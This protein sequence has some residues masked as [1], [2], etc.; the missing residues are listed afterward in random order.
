M[1]DSDVAVHT[2]HCK[3]KNTGEHVVVVNRNDYFTEQLSKRPGPH[4]ILGTLE[5]QCA[6][7]Q[8]VSQSQI[9]DVNVGC[10][11][12]LCVPVELTKLLICIA[13]LSNYQLWLIQAK[14]STL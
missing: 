8:S 2:H 14:A 10:S 5:R 3:S 11:V 7:G 1:A 6:G 4:Q 12:H 13:L 9:E